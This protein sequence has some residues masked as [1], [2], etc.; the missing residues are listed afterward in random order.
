M[1]FISICA[2]AQGIKLPFIEEPSPQPLPSSG[3]GKDKLL[4]WETAKIAQIPISY[5]AM[6]IRQSKW[7]QS[8]PAQKQKARL[9]ASQ[10]LLAL[11][12]QLNPLLWSHASKIRSDPEARHTREQEAHSTQLSDNE[13][14]SGVQWNNKGEKKTKLAAHEW[15]NP[16]TKQGESPWFMSR[17]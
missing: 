15:N 8:G 16:Q 1:V 11:F 12:L 5:F 3:F 9:E 7:R 14:P 10:S 17:F 4:P 6:K 13:N 2:L